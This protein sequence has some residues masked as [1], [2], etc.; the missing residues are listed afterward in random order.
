[1]DTI[2]IYLDDKDYEFHRLW[3]VNPLERFED[4]MVECLLP[5]YTAHTPEAANLYCALSGFPYARVL[6]DEMEQMI[7][8]AVNMLGLAS[9]DLRVG[10]RISDSDLASA[11]A[12]VWDHIADRLIDLSRPGPAIAFSRGRVAMAGA[13]WQHQ[14]STLISMLLFDGGMYREKSVGLE[15]RRAR[16]IA[17]IETARFVQALESTQEVEDLFAALVE[18]DAKYAIRSLTLTRKEMD[19]LDAL[20]T[21]DDINFA[22]LLDYVMRLLA[23]RDANTEVVDSDGSM[24]TRDVYAKR[25]TDMANREDYSNV[26]TEYAGGGKPKQAVNA[27]GTKVRD[28]AKRGPG[29][30]PKPRTQEEVDKK[31][32][33]AVARSVFMDIFDDMFGKGSK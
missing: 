6:P 19:S 13:P 28:P 24:W 21:A 8:Q 15:D 22:D 11:F 18:L 32:A 5:V 7:R 23:Y 27:D 10:L 4:Y 30:P 17:T 2:T 12:R 33:K 26:F 1:M 16:I 31:K 20:R 29:R 14:L 3:S 25:T 9:M